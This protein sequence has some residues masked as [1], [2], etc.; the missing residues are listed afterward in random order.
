M[1]Q[2]GLNLNCRYPLTYT[3][4]I[5]YTLIYRHTPEA[6][7]EHFWFACLH[8]FADRLYA[9]VWTVCV[10]IRIREPKRS[11]AFRSLSVSW[12]CSKEYREHLVHHMDAYFG[13]VLW[14]ECWWNNLIF[15]CIFLSNIL[16]IIIAQRIFSSNCISFIKF[17][18]LSVLFL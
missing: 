4:P 10:R 14:V 18:P 11:L 1:I 12:S 8:T 16:I 17:N 5:S 6:A 2:R 15:F 7:Y 3:L 13:F 9:T